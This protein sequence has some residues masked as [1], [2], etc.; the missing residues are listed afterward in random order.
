MHKYYKLKKNPLKA[1]FASRTLKIPCRNGCVSK[2]LVTK[3]LSGRDLNI[4]LYDDF[5]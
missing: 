5:V 1:G 3:C 4:C 2:I